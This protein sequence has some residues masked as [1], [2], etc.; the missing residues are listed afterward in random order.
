MLLTP[1]AAL[2]LIEVMFAGMARHV[3]VSSTVNAARAGNSTGQQSRQQ[4]DYH[5]SLHHNCLV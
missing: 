1:P 2:S 3:V 4:R 5:I